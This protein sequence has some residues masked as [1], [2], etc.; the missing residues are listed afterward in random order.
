VWPTK[1]QVYFARLDKNGAVQPPGEIK[2]PGT[3]GMRNGLLALSASDGT[4]LIAWKNKD[5]LGW[6]LYEAK[7]QPQE[8]PGSMS[9]A[10]SGAAGVALRDGTFLL[11]P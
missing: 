11:F 8:V 3:T 1:G 4:T 10:G 9:S 6:Q 2:T 7:S 5:V